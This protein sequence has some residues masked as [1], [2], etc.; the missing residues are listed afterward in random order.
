VTRTVMDPIYVAQKLMCDK[1]EDFFR[2]LDPSF[3]ANV[4]AHGSVDLR[5]WDWLAIHDALKQVCK[6]TEERSVAEGV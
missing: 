3:R 2:D 4:Q 5:L 6:E 1:L